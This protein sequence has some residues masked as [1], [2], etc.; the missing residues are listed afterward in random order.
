MPVA[1]WPS[2]QVSLIKALELV[3]ECTVNRVTYLVVSIPKIQRC[4]RVVS[5]H[6][7]YKSKED[8]LSASQCGMAIDH[9]VHDGSFGK[10]ERK[11]RG[12]RG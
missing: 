11:L 4:K 9:K 2:I 8:T 5:H 10:A 6:L 7:L 12:G 1:A 3:G